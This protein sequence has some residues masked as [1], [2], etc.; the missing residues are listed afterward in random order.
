MFIL[1]GLSMF[2]IC[3]YLGCNDLMS[4]ISCDD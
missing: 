2:F 1:V 3:L 4:Q